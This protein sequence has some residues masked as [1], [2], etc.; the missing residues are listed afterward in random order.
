M[1]TG[2]VAAALGGVDVSPAGTAVAAGCY[3]LL[4]RRSLDAPPARTA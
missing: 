2:P 3:A 4:T 1:Y